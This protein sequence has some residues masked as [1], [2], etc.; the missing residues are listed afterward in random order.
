[1]LL[2]ATNIKL[3]DLDNSKTRPRYIG[4]F[5]VLE[6]V[7]SNA[8]KLELPVGM[9]VHNVFNIG[10]CKLYKGTQ[11]HPPAIEVDSVNEYELDQILS[12]RRRGRWY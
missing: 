1:M 7:G 3:K 10:L 12:H 2:N 5:R 11:V 9:K 6:F 8:V 4:P